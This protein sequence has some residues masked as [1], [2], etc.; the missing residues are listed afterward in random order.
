VSFEK[1]KRS[2]F[3]TL[4]I[5]VSGL[6]ITLVLRKVGLQNILSHLRT[7]DLRFFFLSSLVYLL[8][9]FLASLRWG[10]LL[11]GPHS[12]KKLFSLC[13]IGSFFNHFM[14]GM[15]GGDALKAYYLYRESG[16]GGSILG[17]VFLDRYV[18]YCALLSI[19]L[20]SGIAGYGEL[21]ALGLH[22]LTPSLFILFLSG[23]LLFFGLRI[24]RR[25]KAIADFYDYFHETLRDRRALGKAFLLSLMIQILTILEI[26][27]ISMGLGQHLSFTALFVFVPLII[28]VMAVPVSISGLGLREGAFVVLF[29]LTGISAEVS[30]SISFLWFLSVMAGS[31]VGLLE[32]LRLRRPSGQP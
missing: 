9:I 1:L 3:L 19:G 2:L 23:S 14:P 8:T 26:F 4:K 15:I 27:L 25:F 11:K 31:F 30:T 10:I 20:V 13:L 24:G 6:L 21:K 5:T 32:Y 12:S 28:T 22:W 17:S 18:G 16:H 7:M 29:G